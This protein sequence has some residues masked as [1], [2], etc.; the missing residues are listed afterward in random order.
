MSIAYSAEYWATKLAEAQRAQQTSAA[1]L[2][3]NDV[4]IN[5]NTEY[6]I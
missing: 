6:L 5:Y 1:F 2:E 3:I 4:A